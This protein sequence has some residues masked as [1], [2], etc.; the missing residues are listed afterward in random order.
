MKN[1]SA[2]SVACS[3]LVFFFYYI[4]LLVFMPVGM[5]A[6]KELSARLVPLG[7][8]VPVFIGVLSL[9]GS[10]YAIRKLERVSE[11]WYWA[12][13]YAISLLILCISTF[14]D[15]AQGGRGLT[16]FYILPMPAAITSVGFFLSFPESV[17][18]VT[19]Y[20]A[21][22]SGII[23]ISVISSFFA[24]VPDI[25]HPGQTEYFILITILSMIIAMPII[26][27]CFIVTAFQIREENSLFLQK[28]KI[29]P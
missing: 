16:F 29:L 4:W 11:R 28:D 17:R 8:L 13:P 2:I 22:L 20:F 25:F 23:S 1:S 10:I 6:G 27:I 9:A 18:R 12:I 21:V 7:L 14:F 19:R 3:S 26:G 24:L 5:I 15:L